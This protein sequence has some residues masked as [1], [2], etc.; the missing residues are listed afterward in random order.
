MSKCNTMLEKVESSGHF[1]TPAYALMYVLCHLELFVYP[2]LLLILIIFD[3]EK[4]MTDFK[5]CTV[6]LL[7]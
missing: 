1:M 2:D 7:L 6:A 5:V 3:H 4:V